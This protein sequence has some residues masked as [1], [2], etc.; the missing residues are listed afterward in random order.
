MLSIKFP[1]I[2]DSAR[3]RV[4]AASEEDLDRWAA[5]IFAAETAEELLQ[6]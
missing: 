4:Q 3:A 6:G 2:S 5:A 1:A